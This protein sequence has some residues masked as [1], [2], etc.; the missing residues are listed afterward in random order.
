MTEKGTTTEDLLRRTK[1]GD[2]AA[3]GAMFAHYRDQLRN[4]VRLRLDRRVAGRLDPSDVLQ[5]A[6]LDVARRFPEYVAAPSGAVLRLA[7]STDRTAADRP[8]PPAPRGEDAR[9]RPGSLALP[10]AL[11]QAS[12]ASLANSS[13]RV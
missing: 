6:H 11:P 10:G 12:S 1:A 4:M 13:W 8:A 9:R 5:E 7:A 2:A 3:L